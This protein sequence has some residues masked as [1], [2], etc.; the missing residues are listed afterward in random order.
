MS[1]R[2][3]SSPTL[4]LRIGSSRLRTALYAALCLVVTVALWLLYAQ[5]YGV[6]VLVLS[7]PATTLLWR[8]RK[9]PT[10]DLELR[11]RQGTWTLER[12]GVQRAIAL[13]KRSISTPWV[14]YLATTDLSVG[15]RGHL[16]LY[17]DSVPSQQIR[18]LRVRLTLQH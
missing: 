13:G 8:L 4:H 12:N 3:S 11:W 17:A 15:R 18:G 1:A 7:P 2:Y 9:D 10:E 5:G 16:W 14:I 6:F